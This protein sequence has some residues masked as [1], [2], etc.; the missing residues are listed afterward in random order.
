MQFVIDKMRDGYEYAHSSG[1][2]WIQKGKIGYGGESFNINGHT[3]F[4][5]YKR[6]AFKKVRKLNYGGSV[7][8]LSKKFSNG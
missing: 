1:S 4:A 2:N 6:G 5:L 8:H 3:A 7:Y